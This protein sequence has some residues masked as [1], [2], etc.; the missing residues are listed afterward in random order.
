LAYDPDA[1]GV[2]GD[3]NSLEFDQ[4]GRL[5]RAATVRTCLSLRTDGEAVRDVVP[6]FRESLCGNSER[7]PVALVLAF[8][9]GGVVITR[10]PG[11]PGTFHPLPGAGGSGG[12]DVQ[13]TILPPEGL[14][15]S[16]DAAACTGAPTAF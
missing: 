10:Q 7:E 2:T 1:T 11:A 8:E 5:V 9:G 15:S 16:M 4:T 13:A 6:A 12:V 14:F 3:V